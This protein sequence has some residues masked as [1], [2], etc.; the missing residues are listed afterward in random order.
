M[1]GGIGDEGEMVQVSQLRVGKR[2]LTCSWVHWRSLEQGEL[3]PPLSHPRYMRLAG[4]EPCPFRYTLLQL[5]LLRSRGA[6]NHP[7]LEH[8]ERVGHEGTALER[9]LTHL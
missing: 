5:G 3:S 1:T 4:S 7:D 9:V 8:T 6:Q 2:L